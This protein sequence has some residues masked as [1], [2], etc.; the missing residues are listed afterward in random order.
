MEWKISIAFAG[1]YPPAENPIIK[2]YIEHFKWGI[3]TPDPQTPSV[4][5]RIKDLTMDQ[6][7]RFCDGLRQLGAGLEITTH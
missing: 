4:A 1:E 5:I 7:A 3:I 6:F 2:N